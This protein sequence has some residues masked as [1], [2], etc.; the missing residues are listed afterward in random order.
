M[1]C[2]QS[3]RKPQFLSPTMQIGYTVWHFLILYDFLSSCGCWYGWLITWSPWGRMFYV[4]WLTNINTFR[5]HEPS[6]NKL[7][8]TISLTIQFCPSF[9]F[10]TYIITKHGHAQ[11]NY[12]TWRYYVWILVSFITYM[13]KKHRNFV[14]WCSYKFR[15]TT[16]PH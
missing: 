4:S 11:G 12:R 3:C 7:T 13:V 1:Y 16:V 2:G 10:V 5:P 9:P 15:K 6:D 14:W 8:K